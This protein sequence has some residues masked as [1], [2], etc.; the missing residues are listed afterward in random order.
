MGTPLFTGDIFQWAR[1]CNENAGL[2]NSN[3]QSHYLPFARLISCIYWKEATKVW[4]WYSC[5]SKLGFRKWNT[6]FH[7]E[8]SDLE[9][10]TAFSGVSFYYQF[11]FRILVCLG[12]IYLLFRDTMYQWMAYK[13]HII[14]HHILGPREAVKMQFKS[15]LKCRESMKACCEENRGEAF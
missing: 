7:V 14:K 10:R 13:H 3:W 1:F 11:F 6:N 9:N 8:C 5:I 2:A 4:I 12:C 15:C